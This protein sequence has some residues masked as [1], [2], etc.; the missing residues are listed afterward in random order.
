M[1]LESG[2]GGV[3]RAWGIRQSGPDEVVTQRADRRK[4]HV[5]RALLAVKGVGR[6]RLPFLHPVW[7]LFK[8]TA[9]RLRFRSTEARFTEI[10]RGNHWRNPES[11]S[12]FGSSLEAT[13]AA[14]SAVAQIVQR[15]SVTSLLDVPCGDFNWMRRVEFEGSYCGG[16]IVPDLVALN[17]ARYGNERR[18]FLVLDVTRDRLPQSDLILCRD[19]LN[20]LSLREAVRALDSILESGSS[21]AALTHYPKTVANRRQESGFVYR[22]LNLQEEP[23][24]WPPP[25]EVWEEPS[26]QGKTL[27][28][29]HL[30]LVRGR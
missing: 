27:A 17:E 29:W 4:P 14:R 10:F 13:V 18:R 25:L 24:N 8:R 20:H 5:N 16:D 15:Y 22:P 21:Y 30:G 28:L 23:F 7:M 2:G 19:C 11:V 6:R 3:H 1:I 26:Q 12:G 9:F